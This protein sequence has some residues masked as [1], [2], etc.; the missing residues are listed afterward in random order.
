MCVALFRRSG[1]FASPGVA[2]ERSGSPGAA[3]LAWCLSGLLVAT[4]SFCYAELGAM[5]PSTGGDFDYLRAAYGEPAAFSYAWF[6]FWIS[7][8]GSIAIIATVFGNYLVAICLGLD[9]T[10]NSGSWQSKTA[11]VGLIV[12]MTAINCAGLK[13]AAK[14]VSVFTALKLVLVAA[15]CVVG[16]AFAAHD[17]ETIK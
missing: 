4:A 12:L 11:A 13:Q 2:L 7:K 15:L 16:V 6:L 3:L 8:P 5:M 10:D 9:H 1:I 17:P 14:L